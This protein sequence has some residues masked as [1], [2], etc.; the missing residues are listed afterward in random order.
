MTIEEMIGYIS[1]A[2]E[3]ATVCCT[4]R[5]LQNPFCSVTI[6]A[7][8]VTA[9]SLHVHSLTDCCPAAEPHGMINVFAWEWSSEYLHIVCSGLKLSSRVITYGASESQ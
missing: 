4:G 1:F 6:H 9:W 2:S 8:F 3:S 7:S 5:W